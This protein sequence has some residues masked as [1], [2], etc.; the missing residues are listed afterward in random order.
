MTKTV[1]F[2]QYPIRDPWDW[3]VYRHVVDVDGKCCYQSHGSNG[4]VF[5]S[6]PNHGEI[7]ISN[8]DLARHI[9]S[10]WVSYVSYFNHQLVDLDSMYLVSESWFKVGSGARG[11]ALALIP[12]HTP[13]MHA[14]LK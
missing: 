11:P 2:V 8:V 5:F 14:A 1:F 6:T 4:Y 12:N 3:Y 13:M 9:F 10:R 7:M